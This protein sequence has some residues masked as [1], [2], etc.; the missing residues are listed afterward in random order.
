MTKK[1][2]PDHTFN[3]PLTRRQKQT[4]ERCAEMSGLSQKAFIIN[5]MNCA[6]RN[7]IRDLNKTRELEKEVFPK[8]YERKN[9]YE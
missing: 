7:L 5:Y 6:Y 8:P 2:K 9:P 3:L 1:K 4:L